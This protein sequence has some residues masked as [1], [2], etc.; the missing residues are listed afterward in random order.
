MTT[1]RFQ[2]GTVVRKSDTL[3][4]LLVPENFALHGVNLFASYFREEGFKVEKDNQREPPFL[5]F[6]KLYWDEVPSLR[7]VYCSYD[8]SELITHPHNFQ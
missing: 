3:L 7:F 8:R 1:N 2:I 6:I 4:Y 5:R